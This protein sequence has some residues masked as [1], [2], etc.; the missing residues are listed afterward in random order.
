MSVEYLGIEAFEYS[1]VLMEY[2][3]RRFD[4]SLLMLIP[5][6]RCYQKRKKMPT[7]SEYPDERILGFRTAFPVYV[8]FRFGGFIA[9]TAVS[10]TGS[11][12]LSSCWML[13]TLLVGWTSNSD[14]RADWAPFLPANS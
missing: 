6:R 9:D 11:C 7:L 8:V 4:V 2:L 10:G 3:H 1:L 5:R 13:L 14:L 12:V